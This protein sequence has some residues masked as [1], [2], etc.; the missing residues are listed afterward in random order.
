MSGELINSTDNYSETSDS[1]QTSGQTKSALHVINKRPKNPD[2]QRIAEV[3]VLVPNTPIK[4][5]AIAG[6]MPKRH[7]I[8]VQPKGGAIFVST[9]PTVTAGN[10]GTGEKISNGETA[11]F[12]YNET[13]DLYA[14]KSGGGNIK[15]YIREEGMI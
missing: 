13:I 4:L 2:P 3:I 1:A 9:D 8:V 6:N 15:V 7:T 12:D 11:Y 10:N 14:I 5:E